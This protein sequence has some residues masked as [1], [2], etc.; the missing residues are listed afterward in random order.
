[1]LFTYCK[2]FRIIFFPADKILT[3]KAQAY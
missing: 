1:M 3:D 2:L